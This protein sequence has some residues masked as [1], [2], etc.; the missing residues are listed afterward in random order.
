[1]AQNQVPA[2]I[3]RTS[4]RPREGIAMPAP[5]TQVTLS[6]PIAQLDAEPVDRLVEQ[7]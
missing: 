7:R 1:M 5:K 2:P 6:L 4:R 3:H